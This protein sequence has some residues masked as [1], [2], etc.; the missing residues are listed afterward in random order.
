MSDDPRLSPE[1]RAAMQAWLSRRIDARR[2]RRRGFVIA[3][4][5]GGGV[6]VLGLAA[7]IVVAPQEVQERWV[8]CYAAVDTDAAFATAV[9]S[10]ADA[11]D[12]RTAAA[13]SACG[14]LWKHGLVDGVEHVTAPEFVLCQRTDRSLAAFPLLGGVAAGEVCTSVGLT[15]PTRTD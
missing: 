7:W 5:V 6:A 14:E 2:R 12:D 10:N 11:V 9:R 3:G 8:D 13:L 15:P 1:R 4:A